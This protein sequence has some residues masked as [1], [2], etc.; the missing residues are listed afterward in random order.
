M[1]GLVFLSLLVFTVEVPDALLGRHPRIVVPVLMWLWVNV[2][3]TFSLGFLYLAVYLAGRWLDGAVPTK[4][5]ERE[6]LVATA[7]AAVLVFVNPYGPSLVLFPI[8]LM[9][10]SKV[11]SNVS[12]WQ[13]INLHTVTAAC[14]RSGSS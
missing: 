2:H 3:G 6:L 11:L 5:R 13:S 10:R 9:G 12:E 8:A 14:T 1:F 7:I 4:G